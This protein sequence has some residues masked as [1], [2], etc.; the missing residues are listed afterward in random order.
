MSQRHQSEGGLSR[1]DPSAGGTHHSG[2]GQEPFRDH[3]PERCLRPFSVEELQADPRRTRP[4]SLAKTAYSHITHAAHANLFSLSKA[5]LDAI[6]LV[7]TYA[8][9]AEVINLANTLGHE[10]I[11]ANLSFILSYALRERLD[12]PSDRILVTEVVPDAEDTSTR[13]ARSD[14]R[15]LRSEYGRQGEPIEPM[16]NERGLPPA[17]GR[18]GARRAAC[19][20]PGTQDRPPVGWPAEPSCPPCRTGMEA[21]RAPPE[22]GRATTR[23]GAAE[24]RIG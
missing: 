5:D 9:N 16:I 14:Q 3:L 11:M 10:Y 24:S 12:P 22:A 23:A 19:A 17:H 6:L 8:A 4:S 7:G 13:I 20:A 15:A 2:T 18:S 1:R 21:A